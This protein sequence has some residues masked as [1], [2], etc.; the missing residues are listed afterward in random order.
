MTPVLLPMIVNCTGSTLRNDDLQPPTDPIL[1]A[2]LVAQDGTYYLLPLSEAGIAKL[3]LVIS[4][5]RRAR[6][7][8]SEREPPEPTKLQ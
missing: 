5:W 8:L 3:F 2:C 4:D 7:F 1:T 6:D